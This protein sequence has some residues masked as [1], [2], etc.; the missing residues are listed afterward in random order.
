MSKTKSVR[1]R[2]RE[3]AL[4]KGTQNTKAIVH[5]V[6]VTYSPLTP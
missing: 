2:G 4:N 5:I 3:C 6:L 1:V